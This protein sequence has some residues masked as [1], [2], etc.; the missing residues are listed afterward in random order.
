VAELH[1]TVAEANALLERVR[2]L[3][4]QMV[5][6]R[7][8]LGIALER[9]ERLGELTG[10]N[11]GG[12]HLRVPGEV[13]AAVSEAADGIKRCVEELTA[14]GIQVKDLDTG[15]VDFPSWRDGEEVLLCWRLGESEIAWWHTLDGGF[16]GRQ[17][18]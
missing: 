5:E 10:S 14:L 4:E 3:V 13:D 6:H 1:F 16:A 7:R 8:E 9:R 15:L 18:L 17:P 12:F 11:G 2:P